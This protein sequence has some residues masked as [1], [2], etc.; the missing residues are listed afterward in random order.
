MS[1]SL[2]TPG[3]AI[4]F[5]T[6]LDY[7]RDETLRAVSER[8]DAIPLYVLNAL[9]DEILVEEAEYEARLVELIWRERAAAAVRAEHDPRETMHVH[10]KY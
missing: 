9:Y 5:L 2:D 6:S 3:A 8:F 10:L 7:S 4:R 1:I